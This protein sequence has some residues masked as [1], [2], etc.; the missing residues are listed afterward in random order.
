MMKLGRYKN[1]F[2][3]LHTILEARSPSERYT[4]ALT[5]PLLNYNT[6][7]LLNEL[8]LR[9]TASFPRAA[10]TEETQLRNSKPVFRFY[11][12]NSLYLRWF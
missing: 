11:K 4:E 1:R 8:E 3:L 5:L 7:N 12:E 6:V 2:K 10:F 9:I